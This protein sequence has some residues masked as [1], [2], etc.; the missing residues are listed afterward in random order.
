VNDVLTN[1]QRV[2]ADRV[3]AEE[4][5]RRRHLVVS[6]S[7]AH[8]YGFP[9]PDSD[10]DLKAI[11]I[12][13]TARLLSLQLSH[14]PAERLEMIDGVQIDYSSN[15]LR[16]VLVGILRGNGNY[17]ERVLGHLQLRV[18]HEL[19]E[20]K[21]LVRAALSKRVYRHYHGFA[22]SQREEWNRTEGRSA[23]KLLYV[24]RTALTGTHALL[25]G[26]ILTDL[27]TL[28]G[29]HGF[30][31]ARELIE[32]KARGELA[33]LPE[34]MVAHWSSEIERAFDVL[35]GA[36]ARSRLPDEPPNVA[37]VD[38]WLLALRRSTW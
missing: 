38:A 28:M 14:S 9:S 18:S 8:A 15:E 35:D 36:L 1:K 6:L 24:L 25:S 34:R 4:D 29:E 21:Q 22:S 3:L 13:P 33:Q 5:T 12:E 27:N 2:A 19:E 20:F 7:G 31:A 17:V 16:D 23:K 32:Q 26:E 37:E 11:H 30:G 10:L